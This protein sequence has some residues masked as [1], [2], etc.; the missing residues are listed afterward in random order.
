MAVYTKINKLE[1]EKF[2]INYNIGSLISYEGIIEGIENTNYKIITEKGT[3]ILTILE[4]R[5]NPKDLP[6][7]INLQ[8][9]LSKNKFKCPI[10]IEDKHKNTINLLNDRHSIIISFLEGHQIE[11]PEPIHCYEV[12]K[13]LSNMQ[14]IT[15]NL[16]L[17]RKNNLSIKKWKQIFSKCIEIN[18]HEFLHLINPIKEELIYLEKN[19][20]KSLPSGIIHCDIFRDNVFFQNNQFS[21][22]IDFYFSCSDFYAYNLAITTNAWCFNADRKFIRKNFELL[23]NGYETFSSLI[24]EEKKYYN[25]LLRGAAMRILITRLHDQLFHP[26][27]ALVVPKDPIEYFEILKWHQENI[28]ID[29]W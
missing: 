18:N 5:V 20:P 9:H 10:P 4:K 12:G 13:M 26:D 1:L 21:G 19:W 2:L 27:G 17:F 7:F 25:I 8:K 22:L 16:D 23:L 11:S 29:S 24:L 15:Q 14:K 28:V 6:F 3:Y